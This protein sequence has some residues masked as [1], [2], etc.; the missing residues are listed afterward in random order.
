MAATSERD[1]V[2]GTHDEEIG[3]LGLQ[4]GVWRERVQQCWDRAGIENGMRVVD[5]GA[6][7]GYATLDLAHRVG[8]E[9]EVIAVERSERF[10]T[11]GTAQCLALGI[12][13]VKF[14]ER[15][16]LEP[17]P[18]YD[19]DA[20]WCRWV[21]SFVT[22]PETL[23][24]NIAGAL[25]KGGVAMFHEYADYGAWRLLPRRPIVEEF[26]AKVM[27]SWRDNGG[28][29]DIALQLPTLLEKRGFRI[30]HLEPIEWILSPQQKAWRWLASFIESG[31][32]RLKDLGRVDQAWV[33]RLHAELR[34]AEADPHT[35]ML[36][37]MVLEII[38]E[39][40]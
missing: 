40:V 13:Q 30:A 26:V 22:Q 16:V 34:A 33:D 19:M 3:R 29:P 31:S 37:P 20:S 1:Y 15:D 35:R 25:K 27:E 36:T 5:V 8:L 39:R 23:V 38:A 28:E 6:G 18:A 21:A 7:P 12:Q 11:H 2:L 17:L 10:V 4:H 32:L 24:A 9:G 14:V